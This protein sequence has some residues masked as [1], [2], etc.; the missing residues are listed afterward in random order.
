MAPGFFLCWLLHSTIESV[1]ARIV[2][3]Y[4]AT[5]NSCF[6]R[7]ECSLSGGHHS[8][9]RWIR[10]ERAALWPSLFI[11]LEWIDGERQ[12]KLSTD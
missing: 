4:G 12:G 5:R 1:P 11:L 9:S 10:L 6:Y 2:T 8:G 3:K 7:L